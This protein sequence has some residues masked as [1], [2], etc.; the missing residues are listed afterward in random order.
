MSGYDLVALI[1]VHEISDSLTSLVKTIDKRLDAASVGRKDPDRLGVFVVFCNDDPGL[2][3]KLK[4]LTAK[5]GLKQV[6]LSTTTPGGPP[7]YR[8]AKEATQ[9]VVIYND[10]RKVAA[11]WALRTG[12]LN[13]NK[14]DAIAE[15]ISKVLPR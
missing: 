11:N 12:E 2:N 5:E 9:T 14:I 3:A 8:V 4:E 6:V 10:G 7:R 15:A 13:A 1:F